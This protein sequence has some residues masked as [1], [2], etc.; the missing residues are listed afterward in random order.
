MYP[1]ECRI[2][3]ILASFSKKKVAR[4]RLV[5]RVSYK[6]VRV[7]FCEPRKLRCDA[8]VD[9]ELLIVVFWLQNLL[10]HKPTP[11][12]HEHP[13]HFFA[14]RILVETVLFGE[15]AYDIPFSTARKST[16]NKHH[17]DNYSSER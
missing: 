12:F 17:A 8:L 16:D 2:I 15:R 4:R 10:A 5:E 3:E 14:N 13:K 1:N 11:V 9:T 7:H 6:N